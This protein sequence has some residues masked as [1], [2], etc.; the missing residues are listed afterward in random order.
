MNQNEA[1]FIRVRLGDIRPNR[2]RD[3]KRWPVEL[4]VIEKLKQSI[5]ETGCWN[6]LQATRN[7]QGQI[8]LRFGHHRLAAGLELF[9]P[10]HE[11]MLEI[12]PFEGEWNLLRA[13]YMENAVK[14]NSIAHLHEIVSRLVHWWD[15]EI[16][17]RYPTWAEIKAA[18]FSSFNIEEY[19]GGDG[20]SGARAYARCVKYGIGREVLARMLE[21]ESRAAIEQ[22]LLNLP[23]TERHKRGAAIRLEEQRW[24]AEKQRVEAERLRAEMEA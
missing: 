18:K 10:D 5:H 9:G 3:L 11:V 2:F 17:E 13:L 24:E 7:E 22:A 16:F 19:F 12:V 21:N 6:N 20:E 4:D 15:D 1:N 8:K 23:P 14:R